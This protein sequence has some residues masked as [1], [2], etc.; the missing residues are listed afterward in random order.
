LV[1]LET[2]ENFDKAML[3]HHPDYYCDIGAHV[4]PTR[5]F[6]LVRERL[7]AESPSLVIAE[8]DALTRE[9][10]LLAHTPEYLTDLD[11]D[12]HTE[13]TRDSEL[14]LSRQIVSAYYLGTGG[15]CLASEL[16]LKH[17]GGM[18]LSG[19]FHHAF[20]DRAEGFCYLNDIAVATRN[21][22]QRDGVG[23]VL[24]VDCDV[25]QGN[26][27]AHIFQGDD[28]V[29]TFSMHQRDNYPMI[30]EKSDLDIELENGVADDKYCETLSGAL[31]RISAEF[32]ADFVF[33]LAG[34][35]PYE[36]DQLGGLELSIDGMRRRDRVVFEWCRASKTPVT[37]VLA[38]GYA[39]NTDDTVQM[40]CNT[41]REWESAIG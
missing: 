14:P 30:K 7:L 38:G 11:G 40:H 12:E 32:E 13:R 2:P 15:T 23:K 5:K 36:H 27:T 31:D 4:F 26:G 18:N 9:S 41:Y 22:Q 39:V 24:I 1:R 21:L 34:V 19:G 33:Y 3:V 16:A 37:V 20:A 17:G 28:T 25:H 29:F 35:D 10:A 8:P 6:A